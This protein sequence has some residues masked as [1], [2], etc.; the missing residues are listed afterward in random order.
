MQFTDSHIHLQ[1]YKDYQYLY[2]D[3]Y[4]YI[5]EKEL[6]PVLYFIEHD[7]PITVVA[8]KFGTKTDTI[9]RRM[10]V[11]GTNYI[12]KSLKAYNRLAFKDITTEE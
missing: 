9:K 8:N 5:S 4:Y 6:E 7:E 2:Q 12:N 1:D 11:M 10:A 3:V